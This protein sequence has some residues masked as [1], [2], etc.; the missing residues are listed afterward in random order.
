MTTLKNSFN[1]SIKWT[2][3]RT[4]EGIN[5]TKDVCGSDLIPNIFTT[6]SCKLD[7]SWGLVPSELPGKKP[8][9]KQGYTQGHS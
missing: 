5:S 7:T 2:V 8:K 6:G 9:G 4:Q 1:A 3:A